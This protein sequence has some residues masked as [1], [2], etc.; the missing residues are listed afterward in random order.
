MS[1]QP[2]PWP[3]VPAG[4]AKVAKKAFGKGSLPIRARD[5]LGAWCQDDDFAAAYGA[6]GAPGI[7]PGAAGDGYGVAVHRKPD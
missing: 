4:T 3:E 7:S 1:M 2:K 6:R 5:Q